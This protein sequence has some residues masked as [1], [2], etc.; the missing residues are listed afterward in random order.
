MDSE[1]VRPTLQ[2]LLHALLAS[3][4]W[5]NYGLAGFLFVSHSKISDQI[6][7]RLHAYPTAIPR[8]NCSLIK[9]IALI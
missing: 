5:T 8:Q 3:R 2:Y 4:T 7:T 9:L 6:V 1:R